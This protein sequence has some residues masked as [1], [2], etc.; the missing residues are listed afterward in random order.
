[1]GKDTNKY[2]LGWIAFFIVILVLLLMFASGGHEA[3]TI[4]NKD[5]FRM[6]Y[7]A[8]IVKDHK[9]YCCD[10]DDGSQ[11]INCTKKG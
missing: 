2:I 1:M 5:C 7:N 11:I 4:Q 6:G 9:I 8:Q 10:V 3:N